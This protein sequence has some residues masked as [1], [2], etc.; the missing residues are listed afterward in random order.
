M[1]VLVYLHRFAEND[2]LKWLTNIRRKPLILR[3]ARQ[4]GKSTLVRQFAENN[5][6]ILN[7]INLERYL[8]LNDI[9]KTMN[10]SLI[11][12]NLEAICGRNLRSPGSLLFLDEIQATPFALQALRYFYEDT[13]EIPVI[14]AGSLLEFTLADHN[15][16]M[17]VG[18][19]E[20]YHL[21]PL[22]FREFVAAI[23]PDLSAYVPL[24]KPGIALP[25]A[26]HRR[27]LE[28]QREYLFVGGMPEAV[29][30]FQ[31]T[32]SLSDC[33]RVHRSIVETYLNDFSK[34]A[35]KNELNLLQK[36][37]RAIPRMIGN[38]I[39]YSTIS[40]DDKSANVKN[41][42]SLLS[43]ARICTPV[44]HSYC[45]GVPL[46]SDIEESTFK[47][48][49]MD[50]GLSNHM[51]GTDWLSISSLNERQLINEGPIAEQ[52][53]GQH[54]VHL[55]A[56]SGFSGVHF[57][58]REAKAGNSE[59]DY[60]ISRG[61]NII[62]IEV[63]SGKSGSLKSIQQ[64]VLQKG[65]QFAVRFDVNQ[66]GLQ[67]V[68]HSIRSSTGVETISFELMSLPLYAVEEINRIIDEIRKK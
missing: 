15:F 20:Y 66:A 47:L 30:V 41:A 32:G 26:A 46:Q 61:T 16:S 52:F 59:V 37:F 10:L 62:P 56:M 8:F 12:N 7:E 54:L 64:F 43:M 35:K 18:R 29:S 63:K 48:I 51:C 42:I 67:Q 4:V 19:V 38:R 58:L 33:T 49:F 21:G 3:G 31:E 50:V 2:L 45:S 11:I 6:L 28:K 39:K 65:V 36:V 9:F 55:N 13:P 1:C 5:N 60:I 44:I 68:N 24:I 23:E 22:T 57:W 17:P 25:E 14:A 34:Y 27:L 40:R 53:I